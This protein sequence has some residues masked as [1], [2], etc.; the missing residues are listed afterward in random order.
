ML[1]RI[2]RIIGFN[3]HGHRSF[4]GL[5]VKTVWETRQKSLVAL[6]VVIRAFEFIQT[7]QSASVGR[8][9]FVPK[10]LLTFLIQEYGLKIGNQRQAQG[11]LFNWMKVDISNRCGFTP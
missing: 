4:V 9:L 8:P 1:L 7:V 5:H 3:K 11:S 2:V 6:A 10:T